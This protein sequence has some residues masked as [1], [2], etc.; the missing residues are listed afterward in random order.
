MARAR[1]RF[2]SSP[3]PEEL[4][5]AVRRA[6]AACRRRARRHDHPRVVRVGSRMARRHDATCRR[7]SPGESELGRHHRGVRARGDV[8]HD[9][10][11]SWCPTA[12]GLLALTIVVAFAVAAIISERYLPP[13]RALQ[14]GLARP[15]RTP[16]RNALPRSSRRGVRAARARVQHHLAVSAARLARVRSAG[17]SRSRAARRQRDRSRARHRCCPK[18]RELTRAQCVGVIL[19]DPTA[20]AHGR[21]FMAALGADELPVQ[22]V[23]FDSAMIATVREAP[24]GL[25]VGAHRRI[26]PR[27]PRVDARRRRGV[28]LALAG[29]RRRTAERAAHR[30]ISRRTGARSGG[31]RLRRGIRRAPAR[32]AVEQR[33][34][35][36]ACIARRTTIRSPSCRT[37]RCSATGSRR[38]WR[39]RPPGLR[40]ARSCTWISITSSAS[41]TRWAQRGRSAAVDRR[42]S[43]QGLHEGGRHGGAPRRRRIHRAVAQ[44]GR[45]GDRAPAS[46]T[47]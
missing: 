20:H 22:R 9:A 37:A 44:R 15:A 17:R 10:S 40:A 8:R 16:L 11:A 19:L 26:A 1:A 47:A 34:R 45:R 36:A 42:A 2:S 41:T 6:R 25:T 3:V 27:V 4:G 39:P 32:G 7:A 24:E 14:R 38:S 29:G 13:L 30:R 33:A 21:L 12:L 28:L 35:R 5:A 43:A 18:F 46:P 23:T 31:G